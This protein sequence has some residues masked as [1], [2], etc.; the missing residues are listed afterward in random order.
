MA[1]DVKV[2]NAVRN[3]LPPGEFTVSTRG[4]EVFVNGKRRLTQHELH[5]AN[6]SARIASG[7]EGV[8]IIEALDLEPGK[9]E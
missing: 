5:Q 9:E 1:L 7:D 2:I 6:R 3:Q 8:R 4:R